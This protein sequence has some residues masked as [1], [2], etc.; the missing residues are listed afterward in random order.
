MKYLHTMVRVT[1]PEASLRF[2]RDALGLEVLRKHEV[3]AGRFAA[4]VERFRTDCLAADKAH[5]AAKAAAEAAKAD[6]PKRTRA[7]A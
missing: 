5:H 2:Y 4:L 3:P 7:K 6:K 1:D